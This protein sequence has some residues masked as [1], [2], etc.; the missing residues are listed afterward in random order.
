[1]HQPEECNARQPIDFSVTAPQE[2][3][4]QVIRVRDYGPGIPED[5]L[6]LVKKKMVN[7][8]EAGNPVIL[9]MGKGDFTST[10][11]YIVLTG[12]T[13]EGFRVNDPNSLENSKQ[14]W[15]YEQLE[16]QIR[17]IWEISL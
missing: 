4:W 17:N 11:H 3:E 7:A 14:L 16:S 10:G 13:E 6:P 9:A 15:S 12:V 5:E 2:D 1:M 8:L